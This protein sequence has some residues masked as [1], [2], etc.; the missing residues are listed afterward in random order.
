MF[1]FKSAAAQA[2][3]FSS[4]SADQTVSKSTIFLTVSANQVDATIV[5]VK[6][7]RSR[8]RS[9]HAL[10]SGKIQSYVTKFKKKI[11]LSYYF[12]DDLNFARFFY[13]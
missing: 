12:G 7:F 13:I 5:K 8:T 11:I 10:E 4:V 9:S 6:E 2:P 1:G 3:A